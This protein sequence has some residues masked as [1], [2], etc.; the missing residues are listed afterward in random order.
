M[1]TTSIRRIA[2]ALAAIAGWQ[3]HA[4]AA[5]T[6]TWP[7]LSGIGACQASLQACIDNATAGD[8]V[9]VG[10]DDFIL[11]DSYTSID[12]N[13]SINKSLTLAARDGI[14]AVFARGR[15]ITVASPS[16]G[17]MDVT[18]RRLVLQR[19]HIVFTH[20][21]SDPATY[22][23]RDL[24]FRET[25]A[26]G[27]A[28]RYYD[29]GDGSPQF[30]AVDNDFQLGSS[31]AGACALEAQGNGGAWG[32]S[33]AGNH[34]DLGAAGSVEFALKV[35]GSSAGSFRINANQ[36]VGNGFAGGIFVH[37]DAASAANIWTVDDNFVS[38]E[39]I[40]PTSGFAGIF[41][42]PRNSELHVINNTVT[43]G[44]QG[45]TVR[46]PTVSPDTTS[47]MLANNVVAYH[48]AY[49]LSL[50]AGVA[51]RN[52]LV[53]QN[54]TDGF[55]AGPGTLNLD[56][57]VSSK[58]NPRPHAFSPT[59]NA[60][61]NAD[62]PAFTLD[63]DGEKRIVETTVDIGA[64]EYTRDLAF[65]HATVP[66]DACCNDTALNDPLPEPL[67]SDEVMLATPQHGLGDTIQLSENIGVYLVGLSPLT[68]AL[69]NEDTG[70]TMQ[71]G[72]RF[73][74]FAPYWGY[75]S[76]V[77]TTSAG[78]VV[79]RYTRLPALAGDASAIAFVTH[80][81]NPG[82]S[83]GTYHDQRIG[84]ERF[85]SDW[86]IRNEDS[87]VDM[88]VGVSFNVVVAPFFA[89]ANA[90]QVVSTN[91]TSQMHLSHI[92]LDDNPC[93]APQVTRVDTPFTSVGLVDDNVP[94]SVDYS[95]GIGAAPGHWVIRA[96]GIGS[97]TFPA[98]AA[99]NVLV[100]GTQA[101][102]C[103]DNDRI[104]ANGYD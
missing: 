30:T 48:S 103:R 93:T 13:I 100:P 32:G 69:F 46:A 25:D 31:G 79:G 36:I 11:P 33:F 88:P 40:V 5:T 62:V 77:H 26:S 1:S 57:I 73:N 71:P 86:Y 24:R 14:D 90:F 56:P 53:W 16:G 42:E 43:D 23:A 59:R 41:I 19:G 47:G 91:A 28:I 60:G 99:F 89:T 76:F 4:H 3:T 21:S 8:T 27:C 104:F 68:W 83:G 82:G 6:Y 80:N 96:E 35:H 17:A 10:A 7:N 52:N 58:R 63:A 50:W 66:A 97:P 95:A 98:G 18:L 2:L 87:S 51:N 81:W 78:S 15:L 55:T 44:T 67:A 9:L 74:V 49:G 34:V 92:L 94:L 45:I 29:F 22:T 84:L 75:T 54:V 64:F 85:G 61:S 37:Q 65:V 101:S 38:G 72:N 70:I 102:V 20:L 12:E 39:R